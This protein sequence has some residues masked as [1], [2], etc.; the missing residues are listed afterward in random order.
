VVDED[1]APRARQIGF[2][3]GRVSVKPRSKDRGFVIVARSGGPRPTDGEPP[4]RDGPVLA[5]DA[6][7][8]PSGRVGE[9]RNLETCP[10]SAL[11]LVATR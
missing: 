11:S 10:G 4:G 6:G 7:E 8:A 2:A 3:I 1:H 9:R 5:G